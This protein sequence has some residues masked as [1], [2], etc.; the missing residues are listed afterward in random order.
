[1]RA[2][3]PLLYVLLLASPLPAAET[4]SLLITHGPRDLPRIALTF[5]LCQIPAKPA[6]FD[7]GVIDVLRQTQTPATFF[8]GGDWLRTHPTEGAELATEPR[9]VLGNHSWSHP[10]LR[11]LADE[12][13]RRE[14]EQSESLLLERFGHTP[15]LFRLPFGYFDERVLQAATA[16]GVRIIQ[17][18]V[19]SGDPD[20]KLSRAQLV[21]NAT[22]G[23]RNGSIIIMHANGRGWQTS[24]ALPEIIGTLRDRGFELVTV[25]DLLAGKID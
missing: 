17:W 3:V 9:F 11:N 24:A 6:G 25:P 8:V 12:A 10:D 7:R 5:D 20:R 19:V 16:T 18:E 4:H 14:I 23:V 13:I 2:L 1:V 15:R 22:T 21:R